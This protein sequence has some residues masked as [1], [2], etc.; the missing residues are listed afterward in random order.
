MSIRLGHAVVVT[1]FLAAGARG[2]QA[3]P[4]GDGARGY[5]SPLA[6]AVFTMTNESE[7]NR[8]LSFGRHVDG[9]LDDA[10]SFDTEGTG[11]GD[12][13]GSQGAVALSDNRRLL[14][15]VNAGSNDVSSFAVSGSHLELRD[16]VG[17]GGTRPISVSV[18]GG[19][20]YVL[21]AG[22]RGN[23]TGFRLFPTGAL[24]PI[25]GATQP[26]S[27][28]NAGPAQVEIH[29]R[30]GTVV[31]TEKSTSS[32]D[33]FDLDLF[34]R[35]RPL[36]RHDSAGKTPFGFEFTSNGELIV[37][38]A[39][40]A[41]MSSYAFSR[42]GD[43]LLISSAVPDTQAAPCWVAISGDDGFAYTANAGSGSI[44]SY[45]VDRFGA[46]R[47]ANARAADIGEGSSPLDLTTDRAGKY[48]YA[49]ERGTRHVGAFQ[50]ERSGTLE[51]VDTVGELTPF[52]TG[53]IGY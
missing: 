9:T 29:P 27:S 49:V 18:R 22:G 35:A 16:R 50:I 37:S 34:G 41:S 12:S 26:L 30:L 52:A 10:V 25:P 43:P 40:T 42:R 7:G 36:Q 28:A 45:T 23:I 2:A 53:L 5:T 33:T 19:L 8:V 15:V 4:E 14:V 39:A 48:L 47:L 24:E 6:G 3:A 31:V 38:E 51:L 44:S 13:L 17:S 21:N 20:V 46:L 11:S 32:I 1:G